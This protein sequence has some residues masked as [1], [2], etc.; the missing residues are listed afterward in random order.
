MEPPTPAVTIPASNYICHDSNIDR[1]Y[2]CNKSVGIAWS[3]NTTYY[4]YTKS[5]HFTYCY[6]NE[7]GYNS[8]GLVA[9]M[10]CAMMVA[11]P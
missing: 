7:T 3:T 5:N 6:E 9:H 2:W 10:T 1:D 11:Q 4:N 8:S